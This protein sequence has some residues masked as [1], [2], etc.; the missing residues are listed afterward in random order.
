MPRKNSA[1]SSAKT[2][3]KTRAKS[4]AKTGEKAGTKSTLKANA[5]K[6]NAAKSSDE[7]SSAAKSDVVPSSAVPSAAEAE[8]PAAPRRTR[9]SKPTATEQLVPRH[10]Y[11]V[12]RKD[13]SLAPYV[14]HRQ[15]TDPKTGR[16]VGEFFVGSFIVTFGLN[17]VVGEAHM[18]RAQQ[19]DA[20]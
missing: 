10:W 1:T 9:A 3:A 11:W 14:F 20:K 7:R 15:S 16:L 4:A 13:G 5:A 2:V 8:R 19:A 18:P 12:R 6:A 17:Q